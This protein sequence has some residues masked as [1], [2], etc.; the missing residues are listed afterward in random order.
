MVIQEN[1]MKSR[2][3]VVRTS[4][5]HL[6]GDY[7]GWSFVAKMN[8]KMKVLESLSTEGIANTIKGLS[9][10]LISWNFVDEEGNELAPPGVETIGELTSDLV[11]QVTSK[12]L[13][14]LSSLNP[15]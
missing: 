12:Y 7:E 9:G 8:P 10:I 13:E 3:M 4:E 2:K 14:E 1:N 15:K 6:D 11:T 5:L